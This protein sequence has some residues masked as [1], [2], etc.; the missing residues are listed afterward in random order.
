VKGVCGRGPCAQGW[1]DLDAA[2]FGCETSCDSTGCTGP[3]GPVTVT[4]PPLPETGLVFAG[5]A[6]GSSFGAAVQT[7]GQHTNVG[8]L[9]E[10]T[11]PLVGGAVQATGTAH[12]NVP[13]LTSALRHE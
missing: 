6:S 10:S 1:F 2:V 7:S 9:G 12:R 5:V 13:G 11:P 4:S 8:V 3:G